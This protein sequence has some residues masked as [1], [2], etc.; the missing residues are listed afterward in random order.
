MMIVVIMIVPHHL[1][2][3]LLLLR[4][5]HDLL[6]ATDPGRRHAGADYELLWS[7]LLLA[8]SGDARDSHLQHHLLLSQLLLLLLGQ[9]LLLL[10]LLLELLHQEG[11]L[12][13]CEFL[14]VAAS[15]TNVLGALTCSRSKLWTEHIV[16]GHLLLLE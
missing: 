12:F 1:L 4:I 11:L 3:L 14:P 2:L 16:R 15:A 10:L 13:W 9:Y 6:T 8:S 7:L 5:V